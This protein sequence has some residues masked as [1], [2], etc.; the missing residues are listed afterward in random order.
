M[1]ADEDLERAF[2]AL[3]DSAPSGGGAAL[4]RARIMLR[5]REQGRRKR[6]LLIALP[7]AAAFAVSAAW[8]AITGRLTHEPSTG[9][10]R[11]EQ[12]SAGGTASG[13]L[14]ALP[15][16]TVAAPSKEASAPAPS[17]SPPVPRLPSAAAA[18]SA[19]SISARE[20]ALYEA[21]HRAHFVTK[22][23]GLSLRDWDA[24]L[25]EYPRGRFALEARY[26][27][28]ISLVRLGRRAEA[29]VALTPFA[30]GAA[31]GYR[32]DEA[33]ELLDALDS[34]ERDAAAP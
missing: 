1:S 26:N 18:P 4:T 23:P 6:R 33:R 30:S 22:D 15:S 11:H 25:A 31:A 10:E 9:R 13:N 27:R 28:A 7:F 16:S 24:Y 12:A 29:R 21:A 20:Q 34:A 19:A 8:A 32:R 3:R 2:R 5:A 14:P 17:Q